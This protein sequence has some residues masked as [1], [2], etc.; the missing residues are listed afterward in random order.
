MLVLLFAIGI[1]FAINIFAKALM[2]AHVL[3]LFKDHK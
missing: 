1:N 2:C 3:I